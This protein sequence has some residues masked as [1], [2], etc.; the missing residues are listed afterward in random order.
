[1][2]WSEWIQSDPYERG[3]LARYKASTVSGGG[4]YTGGTLADVVGDAESGLYS[5]S[6][7]EAATTVHGGLVS[8]TLGA[9]R[10]EGYTDS[11]TPGTWH[12]GIVQTQSV[13]WFD[14]DD[15]ELAT[16]REWFPPELGDLTEG[17]DYEVRPDRTGTEDDAFIEY[18]DGVGQ[19]EG[20]TGFAFGQIQAQSAS[21]DPPRHATA[22]WRLL[23]PPPTPPATPGPTESV[24]ASPMVLLPSAGAPIGQIINGTVTGFAGGVGI[25]LAINGPLS[26]FAVLLVT[27]ESSD[28]PF[29]TGPSGE[30]NYSHQW[31][32]G[33][34]I[35]G[36]AAYVRLPRWR[37][38]IPGEL[39]L[40][41]R[42]R[43]DGLALRGA[44]SWRRGTSRQAT[45]RWRSYL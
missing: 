1:M 2:P 41:Q 29:Y 21:Y 42:Q 13:A 3:T 30:G 28:E 36:A 11:G 15:L 37:Y 18:E 19:V 27:D 5:T 34:L 31:T 20:W 4:A 10:S 6:S 14:T 35:D 25:E 12:G 39:P 8:T 9:T 38:W 17:V 32:I 33:S 24:A 45:N 7:P 26:E 16:W 44:P 22:K 43:D 40:R 23:S